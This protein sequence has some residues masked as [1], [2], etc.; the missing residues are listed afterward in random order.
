MG[1]VE[2]IDKWKDKKVLLIGESLVDKYITGFANK[3]SPDAPVPNI[4]VEEHNSFLGGVGLVLKFIKSLGGIPKIC[5][6]V[7]NDNDGK[8]FLNRVKKLNIDSSS[9]IV[10]KNISTPQITRIKSMNQHL[11]RLETDY[12]QKF[13]KKSKEKLLKHI[14]DGYDEIDSIVILDYGIGDMFDDI[15]IT[16]MLNHIKDSYRC[17]IS[18]RPNSENYYLYEDM[19]LI[20]MTLHKAMRAFSIECCTETSVQ[21]VGRRILNSTNCKNVLLNDIESNSYLFSK[22]EKLNEIESIL[23]SPVRSYVAVGSVIMAVLGLSLGANLSVESAAKLALYASTY[24]AIIPPV[25]YFN[26]D[27]FKKFLDDN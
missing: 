16:T 22:S 15:F 13:S 24:S 7:G 19:D 21:I 3:I 25:K 18:V 27:D 1:L 26:Q 4:R 8:F 17:P 11:L 14:K 9:I 2:Q 23:K 5:T 12:S 10:D 6:I 20:K